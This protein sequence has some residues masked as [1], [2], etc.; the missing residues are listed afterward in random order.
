[1]SG[2]EADETPPRSSDAVLTDAEMPL[3][4]ANSALAQALEANASLNVSRYQKIIKRSKRK[5]L[6]NGTTQMDASVVVP[7]KLITREND[8]Y[9]TSIGMMLGLRVSLFY[10]AKSVSDDIN[11]HRE[12][13]ASDHYVFP[14]GGSKK[15]DAPKTPK[16]HLSHT[17]KFKDYAPRIFHRIRL[18]SGIDT[19]S[20]E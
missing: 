11:P 8:Q 13:L 1:M 18:L 4:I 2:G 9:V 19:T 16:H 5:V 15:K 10:N 7:G 14:P 6:K 20:C 12:A 17:F 3:P